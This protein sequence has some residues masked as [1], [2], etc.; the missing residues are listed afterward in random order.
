MPTRC[1]TC[2]SDE[3]LALL[4][5][6]SGAGAD[7]GAFTAMAVAGPASRLVERVGHRPVVVPARSYG[8]GHGLVR[9]A[10]RRHARLSAAGCRNVDSRRR[11]GADVPDAE[12]RR[13]GSVPGPRF[14]G[15]DVVELSR[16]PA[17]RR[18]GAWRSDRDP[19]QSDAFECPARIRAR[20][21]VRGA[22][23]VAGSLACLGLVVAR[24]GAEEGGDTDRS[25]LEA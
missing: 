12:R 6:D 8:P 22:C 11:R 17:R 3:R 5:P 10:A 19:R 2:C 25:L 16:A 9:L 15:G 1:A 20:L 7:A 23:F 21:A 14:A 24:P 4:D 13:V 18:A